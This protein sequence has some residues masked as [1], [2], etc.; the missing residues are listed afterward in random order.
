[1]KTALLIGAHP[2]DFEIGA[3][4]TAILLKQQGY[5]LVA[6]LVTNGDAGSLTIP[7][8]ELTEVRQKEAK[9]AGAVLGFD[10]IIFLGAPDGLSSFTTELKV[11]LIRLIRRVK[12]DVVFTHAKQDHFPD[13]QV[14]H[15][16]SMAAV[17]AAGGPWYHEAGGSPHGVAMIYGYEVWNPLNQ[18]EMAVNVSDVFEKNIAALGEHK[19]QI[20]D[21]DYIRAVSGLAAYRGVM[22]MAGDHVEVFEVLKSR[23]LLDC[24]KN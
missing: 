8:C 21:V 18:F 13:H 12:P 22:T 1:M 19:S 24:D 15:Q 5:R 20:S 10:E 2:D 9:A 17:T 3:G 4:G 16:L 7:R 23:S 14:V 11:A 6:V